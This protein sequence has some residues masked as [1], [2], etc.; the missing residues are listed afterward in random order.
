MFRQH[1]LHFKSLN[2]TLVKNYIGFRGG[3]NTTLL[4]KWSET[5]CQTM[6]KS[7]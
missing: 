5:I 3:T 1:I 6:L 2:I 4:C 7:N